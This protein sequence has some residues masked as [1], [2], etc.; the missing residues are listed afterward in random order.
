MY[1]TK[2]GMTLQHISWIVLF[3][4]TSGISQA[5]GNALCIRAV[6][7]L[8]CLAFQISRQ[9]SHTGSASRWLT[10]NF[11][12]D[13][14]GSTH[15]TSKWQV[16]FLK[17][18]LLLVHEEQ[19]YGLDLMTLPQTMKITTQTQRPEGLQQIARRAAVKQQCFREDFLQRSSP[20]TRVWETC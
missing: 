7:A 2:L 17:Q 4:L 8:E 9:I 19:R 12:V 1:W 14:R 10:W 15:T 3:A 11:S 13:I 16:S 5:F 6:Q 18:A 20:A